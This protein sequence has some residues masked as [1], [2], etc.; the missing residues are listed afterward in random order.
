MVKGITRKVV[1]VKDPDTGVFEQAIFLLK[2][3]LADKRG[4]TEGQILEEARRLAGVCPQGA[5]AKPHRGI[6]RPFVWSGI[7]AGFTALV[8]FLTGIIA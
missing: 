7:G 3:D 2:E 8:W 4:V 5:K 1:V 6:L